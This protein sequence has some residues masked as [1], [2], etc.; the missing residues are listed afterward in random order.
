[1][2]KSQRKM[3]H[4][5]KRTTYPIAAL[6]YVPL[7]PQTV[8]HECVEEFCKAREG[9]ACLVGEGGE[10]V[11]WEGGCDDVESSGLFIRGGT[12]KREG[13]TYAGKEGSEGL[14]SGSMIL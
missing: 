2:H 6:T 4:E 8:D 7:I 13:G 10:E 5:R 3:L 1:M 11:A 9:E 12:S 14:T